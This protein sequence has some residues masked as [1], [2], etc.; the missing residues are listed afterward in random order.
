MIIIN[1]N[2]QSDLYDKNNYNEKYIKTI[3]TNNN[4]TTTN[5]NKNQ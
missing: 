5:N 3:K 2:N 1:E 4:N